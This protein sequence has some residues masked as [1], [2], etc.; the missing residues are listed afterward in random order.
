M[1]YKVLSYEV[2]ENWNCTGWH[3]L[4]WVG[5]L[6][7]CTNQWNL[8]INMKKHI[9]K[10]QLNMCVCVCCYYCTII[11]QY[12][13]LPSCKLCPSFEIFLEKHVWLLANCSQLGKRWEF[14]TGMSTDDLPLQIISLQ[15]IENTTL[16]DNIKLRCVLL[17]F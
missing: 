5:C 1:Y 7:A 3:G 12:W 2:Q 15:G 8:Q 9:W 13:R 6:R 10:Y 14:V 16:K 4:A 11:V 17:R